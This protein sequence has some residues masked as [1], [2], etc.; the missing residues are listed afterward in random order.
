MHHYRVVDCELSVLFKPVLEGLGCLQMPAADTQVLRESQP[1]Y[2]IWNEL[3]ARGMVIQSGAWE[4]FWATSIP[5]SFGGR[6]FSCGAAVGR[7]S[8]LPVPRGL[9]RTGPGLCVAGRS[10]RP[11]PGHVCQ[12]PVWGIQPR[13]GELCVLS[14]A[15]SRRKWSC[16]PLWVS[17]WP[18][19]GTEE[20]AGLW[21]AQGW[22]TASP[23]LPGSR[24]SRPGQRSD[25]RGLAAGESQGL[26]TGGERRSMSRP[27]ARRCEAPGI[28]AQIWRLPL[29][30]QL[31]FVGFSDSS[32]NW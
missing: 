24:L 13:K 31:I 2:V 23:C 7:D 11:S 25:P 10:W 28:W 6:H 15:P 30:R 5:P 9:H 8:R 21:L 17:G 19:S 1:P 32:V 16:H 18:R 12:R 14:C 22:L 20:G 3:A 26:H 4:D 27:G 29:T